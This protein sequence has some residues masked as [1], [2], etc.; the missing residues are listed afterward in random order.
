M[1]GG[2]GDH[3]WQS[4]VVAAAAALLT[5]PFRRNA[6]WIRHAIWLAA[7]L[8]F[9]MPFRR[10]SQMGQRLGVAPPAADPERLE[11][12][13]N[14]VVD[15]VVRPFSI[16]P[17]DVPISAVS[18]GTDWLGAVPY[19]VAIVWA[20]GAATASGSGSAAGTGSR[21][22]SERPRPLTTA[23]ADTASA[24]RSSPR[25]NGDS[26]GDRRYAARARRV[27]HRRPI[28][29]WP[30]RITGQLA[31]AH[32]EAI[33]EHELCHV[34]AATTC[35]PPRIAVVQTLF[36]FHP[37]VWWIGARLVDERE[38]ACDEIVVASG[39]EPERYAESILK[40]CQHSLEAPALCMAGVTGTNLE[41]RM[42]H[43]MSGRAIG[44]LTWWK[45][46]LIASAG[47]LAVAGPVA[48]GIASGPPLRADVQAP[49]NRPSFEVASVKPNTSTGP[50]QIRVGMPGNGRFN[51]TNMPLAE[52]IRFA[53]ES[54]PFQLTGGPDWV[55]SQRFDVTAT[56]DGNPGAGVIR[57]ML[58]SL[59]AER[60]KL[61]VRTETRDMPIYEM[62]LARSDGRLGEKLRRPAPIARR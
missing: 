10:S 42:E 37:L 47:A 4:T 9:L 59:L 46:T 40:T 19:V 17:A 60:F 16:Q 20:A 54:Q 62:V 24:S 44:V 32:I 28:L 48:V 23:R 27:R 13:I 15:S 38:R 50:N 39:S 52:L 29:V 31:D 18:A 56:T 7:S 58:Q 8:K 34:A 14:F 53:Y 21:A 3:L 43:I 36:W 11:I 22:S 55:N 49:E 33:L 35:G 25:W 61:A 12:Q 30:A 51:I 1:L 41:K 26:R 57:Q 45:K 6:A 2:N 5:I